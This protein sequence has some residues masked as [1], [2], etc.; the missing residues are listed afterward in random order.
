MR[1]DEL[2]ALGR[3]AGESAGGLT[4]RIHQTHQAIA[5]RAF[6][7]AGPGAKPV[8]LVHDGIA[9]GVYSAVGAAG[10]HG[11]RAAGELA[12]VAVGGEALALETRPAGRRALAALNGIAGDRLH[13]ERSPLELRMGLRV[14]GAA[15]AASRGALARA[16]PDATPRVAVF[17]HGLG[18]SE[19]IWRRGGR[20]APLGE[21]LRTRLGITPVYVRYNSGRPVADSG[22]DLAAL[23]ESVCAAWP[24]AL[25]ELMLIGHAL[26]GLVVQAAA[27]EEWSSGGRVSDVIAIGTPH[28]GLAFGGVLRGATRALGMAPETRAV[29]GLLAARSAGLRESERGSLSGFAPGVR[30]RFIS[31]SVARDPTG[32]LARRVGDLVVTRDSAWAHDAGAVRFDPGSYVQIG[33]ASHFALPVHPAVAEQLVRWL[34]GPPALPRGPASQRP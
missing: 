14:D 4:A 8:A 34:S 11:L 33:G 31:G 18:Q 26:G 16:Y 19:A 27:G 3:L 10:R 29:A 32:R 1:R 6:T 12:A 25:G 21:A 15:V 7:A 5:R 30:W 2:R 22:R 13:A 23:L 28:R 20:P 9:T 24:V 17:V